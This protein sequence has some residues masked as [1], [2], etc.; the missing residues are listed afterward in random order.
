MSNLE[1]IC[2]GVFILCIGFAIGYAYAE[3]KFEVKK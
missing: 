3:K 1:L 2:L